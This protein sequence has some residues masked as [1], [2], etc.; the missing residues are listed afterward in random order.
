MFGRDVD[1][2]VF[3]GIFFDRLFEVVF[4]LAKRAAKRG[5]LT[6]TEYDRDDDQ[7]QNQF[8]NIRHVSARSLPGSS[9]PPTS[10]E[11]QHDDVVDSVGVHGDGETSQ[12][13]DNSEEHAGKKSEHEAAEREGIA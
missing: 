3:V 12:V 6:E 13:E 10:V 1:G 2:L 9:T 8:G 5:E 11:D 4:E 7:N